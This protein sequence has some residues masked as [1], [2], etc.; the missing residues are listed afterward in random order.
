MSYDVAIVGGGHNGLTAAAYCARAGLRTVVLERRDVLGGATLTQEV[1]PGYRV[2]VASYVC[3]LLDPAVV[4]DLALGEHGYEA[5]RKDPA[6]FTPLLDGRSLLLGRDDQ[7]NAREIA[8]FDPRDVAGFAAFEEEAT[9]LGRLLFETFD[10][11]EPSFER[12]PDDVQ[13]TLRG[14]VA[15][16]VERYVRTPALAATLSTDGLIGTDAGPRDPGTAYVMAHHYAGRALGAQGAWGFV[17]GGMGAVAQAIAS[18]ARAA[19]AELRTDA[20]VERIVVRDGRAT[21]LELRSGEVVD[22]S[23]IL[24]NADPKTLFLRLLAPGDVPDALLTRARAWRS[25]GVAFKL[26]LALGELPDFT[27]RPG[28]TPQPHHRATIHVTPSIDYLQQAHADARRAGTSTAPMLECFM[29]S[30][31]DPSM[32]PAGK[33]VLS[34][35]AQYFPYER[36]DRPWEP[37]DREQIADRIVSTLAQYAPNLPGAIEARQALGAPDLEATFGLSGGQIFHGELVPEQIYERRFPVRSG[38]DGLYV[39][40]SGTHPGGCVSGFPGR[41]AAQAVLAD[42]RKGAPAI[43]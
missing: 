41:R 9:R 42:A 25:N 35:F 36:P 6:S 13:A 23:A 12:F 30:P 20:A 15:A 7:A 31:T 10:D 32:V 38:I 21:R 17:R 29:Q 40:G 22:V 5:Y 18:A 1:W 26:N 43:H 28:R 39:C 37:A 11:P 4:A 8:R 24:V 19:G 3:S 34:V 16:L 2:S 14:S 27:A 33:H